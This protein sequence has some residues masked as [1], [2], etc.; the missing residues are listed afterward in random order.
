MKDLKTYQYENKQITF[1]LGNGE[2][3]V[4]ATEMARPF[5][6]QPFDF[7]RLEQTKAFIDV[8]RKK[9]KTGIPVIK[10]K[11]GRHGGT[12]MH[13]KLALKFAAWLS[14]EFELWCFDRIEELLTTG[15]T[16]IK[17][18]EFSLLE[19]GI[20]KLQPGQWEKRF[21]DEFFI[22]VM[23]VW[24]YEF[25]MSQWPPPQFVG[26]IIT[27]YV[28]SPL[29]RKIPNELRRV[30]ETVPFSRWHQHLSEDAVK[31]L[32]YHLD[33]VILLLEITPDGQ[34]ETFKATF[35]RK[36][37]NINQLDFFLKPHQINK[38]LKRITK[39]KIPA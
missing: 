4:N 5:G 1:D 15:K 34:K 7:I 21:Q 27:D 30:K 25:D 6:K 3:M 14:P 32:E 13:Q 24:G 20:L 26:K 23:R 38:P 2:V 31:A 39:A 10:Q 33:A 8:F 9:V 12:W 28:Y 18:G 11:T 36:F 22:Q 37:H 19:R 29:H 16:E 17:S 35:N